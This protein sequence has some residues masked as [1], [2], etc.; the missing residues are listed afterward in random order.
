ME[1]NVDAVG[2][3]R[4]HSIRRIVG[5]DQA[6]GVEDGFKEYVLPRHFLPR[7]QYPD[8]SV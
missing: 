1:I 3:H 5:F 8:L 7:L 2:K 4:F 6:G